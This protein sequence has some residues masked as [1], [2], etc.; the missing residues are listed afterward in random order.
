MTRAT[1]TAIYRSCEAIGAMMEVWGFKRIMGMIWAYLYL[2][3]RPLS[4]QEIREGLGISAGLVSMVINDLERWGVVHKSTA[5]GERREYYE[6]EPNIWSP[7]AKVLR[8]R[9]MR[10][11]QE[12]LSEL[13]A[14]RDAVNKEIPSK[15]LDDLIVAGD[16]AHQ[17]LDQFI[18]L[19]VLDVRDLRSV[20]LGVGL[21]RTIFQLKQ[22]GI[23]REGR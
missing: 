20:G 13:R 8:E 9:E 6:A 12:T 14:A 19:G 10:Q 11:M 5:P 1:E 16:L 3:D 17:L 22:L 15:R 23:S 2:N 18:N 4:A 21:T 7:I